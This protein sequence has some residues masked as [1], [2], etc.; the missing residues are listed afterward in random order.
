[1]VLLFTIVAVAMVAVAVLVGANSWR[2]AVTLMVLISVVALLKLALA[3][4][5]FFAMLKADEQVDRR[6]VQEPEPEPPSQRRAA[7]VVVAKPLA[8]RAKPSHEVRGRP[9]PKIWTLSRS[10]SRSNQRL[11]ACATEPPSLSTSINPTC[12]RF[13]Q[14]W[15]DT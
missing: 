10:T 2:D 14:A 3:D 1:M 4:F 7:K 12:A 13:R 9:R 11:S 5:M 8:V 6:I 15:S